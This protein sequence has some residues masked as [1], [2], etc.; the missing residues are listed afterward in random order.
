MTR[1]ISFSLYGTSD[2]YLQGA[3]R[4]VRLAASVYPQWKVRIYVSEEI[5]SSLL[6]KMES[7][8]AEIIR[9]QRTSVIDGMFWRFYPAAD[10]QIDAVIIRDAD[11]RLTLRERLAVDQWL[12]SDRPLHIMRDHP[13]H[14]VPMMGGLWGCRKGFLSQL[15]LQ[16]SSWKLWHK[17]GQDQ[18]FLRDNVY[19]QYRHQCFVHSDFYG[20]PGEQVHPFPGVRDRG[21]FAGCVYLPDR[22][23]LTDEQHAAG[24]ALLSSSQF[25]SLPEPKFPRRSTLVAN[26]WLRDLRNQVSRLVATGLRKTAA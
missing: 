25:R 9:Q 20:Y 8:G 11:S 21:E 1:L 13:L 24:Q 14:Q 10:P 15:P 5:D 3:L 17:K 4:N 12:E 23:C 26:Q 22:D 7:A 6:A 16:V 18:D 19:R 2:V